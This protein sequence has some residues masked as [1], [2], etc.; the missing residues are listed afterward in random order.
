MGKKKTIENCVGTVTVS[1]R[2]QNGAVTTTYQFKAGFARQMKS[3]VENMIFADKEHFGI[4]DTSKVTFYGGVK[5]LEC[6]YIL[7]K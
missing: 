1:T 6:D 2:I 3:G 4:T 5:V 7:E